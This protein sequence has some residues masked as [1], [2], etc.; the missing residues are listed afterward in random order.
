MRILIKNGHVV[1][2]ANAI[3]EIR[4]VL[5]DGGK[6]VKAGK[7]NGTG[8]DKIIDATGKIVMP[9]F[10]DMHVHLREP[11]REDKETIASGTAAAVA[12]G[13]TSVLA[14]PNTQ[15]SL[16]N[17]EIIETLQ[18]IIQKTAHCNVFI[19]GAITKE[20]LGKDLVDVATVKKAGVVALSDDGA[21]V[22]SSVVMASALKQAKKN[23]LVVI[24]HSED[25][26][27]SAGG[28]VNM[29]F[30]STRL[31]LRGI[32]NESEYSRVKRDIELAA[33]AKTA[34]HIAHVSCKESVELIRQAKRKGIRVTA[35]TAP[36]Y[37][38]LTDEAVL[39]Y[40]TNMKMNPPLR[41]ASD[42]AAVIQGLAD[43]TIDA[44]ASD[45]APHTD[46]EKDV[47]FDRA[48]F[49]TIGLETLFAAS[50]TELVHKGMLDWS[51]LARKLSLHPARILGIDKGI[52]SPGKAADI[53]II[54][55]QKSWT[56]EK[57]AIVSMSKN[58]VFLGKAFTGA[59]FC[60]ICSG[61]IVYGP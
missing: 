42:K 18:T 17:K 1:D 12:G 37:F 50:V 33:K 54:D 60:T 24:C 52:L 35:E 23:K 20:R 6:I 34:V 48:E 47:E 53:V 26:E 59:V 38:S 56:L 36:H 57:D 11:G 30:T 2:P 45:H 32:S 41:N 21:S 49:G 7:N 51:A 44:I 43:N 31:G 8:A 39:E 25:K 16:D 58:S 15:P 29:G 46:N 61:K 55:P 22:D 14:M 40:D 9:G 4:D 28:V 10:V 27:L 19:C 5:I 13:V 3:D